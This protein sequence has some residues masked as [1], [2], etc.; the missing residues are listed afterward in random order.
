MRAGLPVSGGQL[1]SS[2]VAHQSLYLLYRPKRFS[3]IKGQDHVVRALQTAV[4]NQKVGHAYLLH[5]PRGSGKTSTARVL[6]KAM[7]CENLGDDGEPCCICESCLSIQHNRSFDLQELDAASNNKVD[8]MRTL[9]ERVN[10][11]SPGRAKVY[12]LDEVHMLTP[13]AENALLKTL[14]EPPSHVTWVLATTEPHKVAQTIRSRCQVFELGLVGADLMGDHVRYIIED[15][16]LDVGD[17]AVDHVVSAGGG[18]VRDTL[19]AL[20][21]VAA[22]GMTTE[23]DSSVDSILEAIADRDRARALS[24]VGEATG[25]G[26]DPRTI[27]ETVLAGLRDAFLTAMGDPPP[28]AAEHEQARAADLA[29]RMPPAAITRALETLGRA[30]VDMRQAP[31]PRVDIE[32]AL[33]RLCQLDEERSLEALMGRVRLLEERLGVVPVD[34]SDPPDE[35][36]PSQPDPPPPASPV[37]PEP[38][39]KPPPEAAPRRRPDGVSPAQSARESLGPRRTPARPRPGPPPASAEAASPESAAPPPPPVPG[40]D[41]AALRPQT[42][43]EVV[44]LAGRHLGLSREHVIERA[45]ELL[46]PKQAGPRR[47]EDLLIL[48]QDLVAGSPAQRPA[49]EQTPPEPLAPHES[50]P[51][52]APEPAPEPVPGS[53]S[54]PGPAPD[55]VPGSASDPVPGS[56]SGPCPVPEPESAF[57]PV[58]GS[59]SGP[60]PV[61]EPESAF[62]PALDPGR[63]PAPELVPVSA[64]DPAPDPVPGSASDP[65]PDP[66][67]GAGFD[68]HTDYD[69]EDMIDVDDLI[70]APSHA[71]GI[72]A[73]ILR[74]FPGSELEILPESGEE[75]TP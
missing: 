27:G 66:V 50:G 48:W 44:A 2:P 55:P 49:P 30:L 70:E 7:N 6:A 58:P 26:R 37:P 35:E 57:D 65:A 72:E 75:G 68:E 61:P 62:D 5:G 3:E 21:R 28:R 42:A 29:Q 47:P 12:L 46:P 1:E 11:A 54:G 69:Y 20:D 17:G 32:V 10:L 38:A 39:F 53:A 60:G 23:L 4:H 52:P 9:L 67:A 51:D 31:D 24:A 43:G 34:H 36:E 13:G 18:S 40:R 41:P 19:S 14:E 59:A 73:K 15:A 33:V 63:G 8:D 74:T 56:A 71:A 64:S 25:R 45:N 16:G 22:G